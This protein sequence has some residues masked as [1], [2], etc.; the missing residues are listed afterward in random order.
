[1][2]QVAVTIAGRV[3]RMACADGEEGHLEGLAADLD[4]RIA[5]LRTAFG[6]IGDQR[7]TVMAAL[8]IAD[9]KMESERRIAVLESQVQEL[10]AA[11]DSASKLRD[12]YSTRAAEVVNEAA[13]RV[14]RIVQRLNAQGRGA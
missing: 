7:L 6:E 10:L 14:E 12:D 2:G 3:Y 5:D 11:S 9:E 8:A 13:E 4:R 1:M